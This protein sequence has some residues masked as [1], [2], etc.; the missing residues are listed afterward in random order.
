[1]FTDVMHRL[2]LL[3]LGS[4]G[5]DA[6]PSAFRLP[7]EQA[8]PTSAA[9]HGKLHIGTQ[10]RIAASRGVPRAVRYQLARFCQW[11]DD[12]ADEYR[13]HATP[14]SL[15]R[16]RAQGLKVEHLLTLLA[17]AFEAGSRLPW[18]KRSNAGKPTVP[19]HAR[20]RRLS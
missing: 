20:R 15:T 10:G 3:E 2:G 8:N 13:Y 11:D 6:L 19:R 17:K 14:S 16:A 12:K 1:M 9:E 18:S 5:A 7:E 4:P